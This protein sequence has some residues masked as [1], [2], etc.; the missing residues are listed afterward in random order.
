MARAELGW[1][2]RLKN[3]ADYIET[4][5]YHRGKA[6]GCELCGGSSRFVEEW[7]DY[8]T[9][10]GVIYEIAWAIALLY[11]LARTLPGAHG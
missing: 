8:V 5:V 6:D 3:P 10:P 7:R 1:R 11:A 9:W 4:Q 2:H